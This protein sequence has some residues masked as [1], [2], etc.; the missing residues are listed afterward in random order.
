MTEP[1][2]PGDF[3]TLNQ[4][5]GGEKDWFQQAATRGSSLWDAYKDYQDALLDTRD[6]VQGVAQ[7]GELADNVPSPG[8][9]VA[10][11]S[12]R[13][14]PLTSRARPGQACMEKGRGVLVT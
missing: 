4:G 10:A 8:L 6:K 13:A 9:G 7:G 14:E 1:Q 5:D 3:E 2:G 11:F 12:L